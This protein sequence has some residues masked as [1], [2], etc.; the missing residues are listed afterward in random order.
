VI[1]LEGKKKII[2]QAYRRGYSIFAVFEEVNGTILFDSSQIWMIYC[3]PCME[4]NVAE[5][6]KSCKW[7]DSGSKEHLHDH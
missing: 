2:N 1:V 4:C 7:T 3:D 5:S 6:I